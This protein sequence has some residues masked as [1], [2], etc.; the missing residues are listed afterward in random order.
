MKEFLIKILNVI[1]TVI[2][3]LFGLAVLCV[4]WHIFICASFSIPSDSMQPMIHPG[5]KV[6]VCKF[7]TGARLF[8][9]MDAA[10][11][12]E[13][14]VRRTP[15][16]CKFKHNDILV[17]NSTHSTSWDSISMDWHKYYVKRCIGLPGDTIVV[18]NFV[19]YV[20]STALHFAPS[21]QQFKNC[22]PNDSVAR[23]DVRGYIV[24]KG[25]TIN[26]WTIKDFGPLIVPGK[27]ITLRIAR[28]NIHNYRQLIEWETKDRV[29]LSGNTVFLDGKRIDHYTFEEDYY[30]MAGDNAISSMDSR[31]W[32]FVP[33]QFVVG[34]AAFIWWSENYNG[35]QWNRILKRLK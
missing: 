20:N 16:F 18:R 13:L 7:I 23:A 9:Y 24:D 3:A 8:N 14:K 25:D 2:C 28:S 19:Y 26:H 10:A 4:L 21:P 32:G 33:D 17:F 27:G 34:K 5:D 35:I 30:F 31:Y 29:A 22:F 15:R 12:R 1:S 6:F 11:G